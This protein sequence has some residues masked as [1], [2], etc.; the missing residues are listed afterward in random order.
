MQFAVHTQADPV[1]I[2]GSGRGA[3]DEAEPDLP[4]AHFATLTAPVNA[5][6]TADRFT[7]GLLAIFGVLAL[8]LAAIARVG[9]HRSLGAWCATFIAAAWPALGSSRPARS[10]TGSRWA[11]ATCA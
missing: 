4:I 2:P 10:G 3:V 6:M 5:S 11:S 8:I 1:S 7:M 9:D